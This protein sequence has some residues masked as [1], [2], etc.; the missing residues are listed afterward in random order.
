MFTERFFIRKNNPQLLKDLVE[1]GYNVENNVIP[2]YANGFKTDCKYIKCDKGNAE[3]IVPICGYSIADWIDEYNLENFIDCGKDF[4][5]FLIIA[6]LRD[7]NDYNQWFYY[8]PSNHWFLSD[9]EDIE[10]E[11]E[12]SREYNQSAWFHQSHKATVQELIEHFK[13]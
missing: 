12:D 3:S 10:K 8:P 2:C 7:D 11:R 9:W 13:K 1:L 4:E 6:A 5:L